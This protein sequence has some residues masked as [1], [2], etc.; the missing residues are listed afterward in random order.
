MTTPKITRYGLAQADGLH[1]VRVKPMAD[2]PYIRYSDHLKALE[3]L[4]KSAE[5]ACQFLEF[6]QTANTATAR[7]YAEQQLPIEM[8]LL[9][10][11]LKGE[12]E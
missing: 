8:K 1:A 12:A 2:G 3:A 10:A 7:Q 5:S 4:R 9:R 11:A 6:L